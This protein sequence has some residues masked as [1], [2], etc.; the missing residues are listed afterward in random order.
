MLIID[1]I[2]FSGED[3]RSRAEL[4]L[5]I[6]RQIDQFVSSSMEHQRKR[7]CLAVHEILLKF[8]MVFMGGS[9]AVGFTLQKPFFD[10][11]MIFYWAD[12]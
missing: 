3:G 7:G 12:S 11:C 8:R 10:Y 2:H 9:C 5:H 4:L 6:L 1:D